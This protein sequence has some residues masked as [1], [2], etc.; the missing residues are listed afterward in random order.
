V[1]DCNTDEGRKETISLAYKVARSKTVIDDIGKAVME[2]AKKIVDETNKHRKTAREFLDSL[3]E[4]IRKPVTE[5]EAEQEKIKQEKIKAEE[6]R[7]AGIREMID[8]IDKHG[9]VEYNET[10]EALEQRI[11][12]VTAM[13]IDDKYM[14]F[15]E[16][17][18]VIKEVALTRLNEALAK[19]KAFEDEQAKQQAENE[20]LEKVRQEQEDAQK[21]IDEARKA[22]EARIAKERA[23]IEAEKKKI[24]DEKD[25]LEREKQAEVE[26]KE[27]EAREAQ[28]REEER[29]KAIKDAEEKVI[30]EQKEKE[31]K[32][33]AEAEAKAREE[34]LKPD[35]DKIKKFLDSASD[36]LD[37]ECPQ[38]N[39]E[40]LQMTLNNFIDDIQSQITQFLYEL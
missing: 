38:L 6:S 21:K 35:K 34:A 37:E 3:K 22:E 14:E 18:Q 9:A 10:S 26:R 2:D 7:V 31:A 20:R 19:R 40:I 15:R 27:R 28:I 30:R 23:E 29:Q 39:D 24:Q 13:E 36:S 12:L 5:W 4:E 1:F 16:E 17:A 33:K 8:N 11:K 25:R 32:E